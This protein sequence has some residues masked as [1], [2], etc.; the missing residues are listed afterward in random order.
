MLL[1]LLMG[2]DQR[3]LVSKGTVL[4]LSNLGDFVNYCF[5]F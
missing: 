5:G 2:S 3:I 1:N 4:P